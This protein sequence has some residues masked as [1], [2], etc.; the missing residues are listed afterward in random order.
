M[1][2]SETLVILIA[3]LAGALIVVGVA[4][5]FRDH[6]REPEDLT[7]G[8]LGPSLAALYLLVLAVALATEWQTIGDANSSASSEASA[9]RQLYW[10]ATGL[11][12]GQ[13]A[14][15]RQQA[16]AYA[17]AVVA[18]DWPQMRHGFVDDQTERMLTS[19]NG[20]VLGINPPTAQ[21]TNAQL[22]AITQLNSMV[23]A[24]DQRATDAGT[25]LPIG[26]V[27]GVIATS[28]VVAA[29]PFIGGIRTTVPSIAVAAVQA[30]LVAVGVVVVFQLN[31][32]YSGPLAVKPYAMHSVI[33]ELTGP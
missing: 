25:K 10:S 28:C 6:G 17:N 20:Y 18:H 33:T 13:A 12:T 3:G 16:L 27:A 7:I 9:V 15:V 2:G 1:F 32:V 30:A 26:L 11:P 22:S 24:R 19:L 29:F 4:W 14:Q 8:F 5:W 21:S 23:N 31:H